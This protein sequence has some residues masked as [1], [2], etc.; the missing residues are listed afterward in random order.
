MK[1]RETRDKWCCPY[2]VHSDRLRSSD[3]K[4]LGVA[5]MKNQELQS[6]VYTDVSDR[7]IMQSQSLLLLLQPG[8][9]VYL[10]HAPSTAFGIDS[11]SQR[12][13][14]FSGFLVQKGN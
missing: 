12:Y 11:S 9:E 13:V 7:N 4:Y 14:T 2:S 3:G 5:L 10:R 8:D 6:A 1:H